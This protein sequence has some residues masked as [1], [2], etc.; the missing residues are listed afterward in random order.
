MIVCEGRKRSDDKMIVCVREGR[1]RE[2]RR[3]EGRREGRTG[4]RAE[5]GGMAAKKLEP[6]TEMWGTKYFFYAMAPT[7]LIRFILSH[8]F[9][10]SFSF[11]F[12]LI[13]LLVSLG[14]L[15]P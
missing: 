14:R 5:S 2:G 11:I 4:G 6:H 9:S 15:T 8:S 13:S 1:R 10:F 3:R 7:A 12:I